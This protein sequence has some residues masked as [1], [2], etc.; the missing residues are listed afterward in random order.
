MENK[1]TT[2][3]IFAR[4][5]ALRSTR[6]RPRPADET[7]AVVL[8]SQY[9]RDLLLLLAPRVGRRRLLDCREVSLR[10]WRRVRR[11]RSRYRRQAPLLDNDP[12]RPP[13]APHSQ[14][15]LY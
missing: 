8:D 10:Y 3:R 1:S 2:P 12:L 5:V 4:S 14:G 11:R 9:F 13:R 7:P 6:R 15:L